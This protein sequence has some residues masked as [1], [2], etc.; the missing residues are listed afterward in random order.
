M[1]QGLHPFFIDKSSEGHQTYNVKEQQEGGLGSINHDLL[2]SANTY[3]RMWVMKDVPGLSA[4]NYISTPYNYVDK[5][6]FQLSKT[7]NGESTRDVKNNWAKANEEL[8]AADY[9]GEQLTSENAE[10][11]DQINKIVGDENDRLAKAKK[12]Y[13]Y[14][15]NNF[16]CTNFYDKYINTSLNS[17]FKNKNGNVGEINLLLAV[18]LRNAQIHA[19]PVLLSTTEFGINSPYYPVMDRLNYVICRIVIGGAVYYLDAARPMLGFGRLAENCYN[20]HARIIC[21]SDSG[22]VYFRADSIKDSK[23]TS[24]FIVNDEKNNGEMKGTFES[25]PGYFESTSIREKGTKEFFKNFQPHIGDD[26]KIDSQA[27]DLLQEYE[28]GVK[29][30]YDFSYKNDI[31]QDVIYFSPIINGGY[32]ENPFKAAERKYPVEMSYPVDE[33]YILNSEIPNGYVVDELPKSVKVSYNGDQG[34]FEYLIQKSESDVQL[35]FRIKL[36][37]ATFSPEDYNSLREFFG[38]VVKKQSEQIVF[39]KKK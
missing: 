6:E 24:V 31:G 15:Q 28:Q 3:K 7:Y 5:I 17:V 22:S 18:F 13:Y 21:K 27:I 9:F 1:R 2:V 10:F 34:F 19:D 8:L 12:I 37:K 16:T 32:K 4:E 26:I 30:H 35:R 23:F 33:T 39:K 14:I 20:G 38:Y 29:I 25:S 11:S 36:N